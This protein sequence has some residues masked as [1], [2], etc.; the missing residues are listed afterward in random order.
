MEQKKVFE[1][2]I[3]NIFPNLLVEA[4]FS[5]EIWEPEEQHFY[6]AGKKKKGQP[7]IL[8]PATITFKNEDKIKTFF[9]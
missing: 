4:E 2:V 7:R 1:E 9:K 3:A 8:Y 6:N 5:S